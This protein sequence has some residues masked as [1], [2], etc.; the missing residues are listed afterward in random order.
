MKKIFLFAILALLP[1]TGY[2]QLSD[3]G[4]A[5]ALK[6]LDELLDDSDS[7][8]KIDLFAIRDVDLDGEMD[9]VLA[10]NDFKR[11]TV[12]SVAKDKQYLEAMPLTQAQVSVLRNQDST[13]YS[14]IVYLTSS[15]WLDDDDHLNKLEPLMI[16]DASLPKNKF[17]F[18]VGQDEITE[19]DEVKLREYTKMVF[20]PHIG[21]VYYSGKTSSPTEWYDKALVWKLKNPEFVKTEF[22]GYN[23]EEVSPIL[24]K[25]GFDK[26]ITLL[27]FSRWKKGE[28]VRS[29]KEDVKNL[30]L[31]YYRT[32]KIIGI[33]YV[34]DCA[35]N[36]RSWYRVV[37]ARKG[38]MSHYALVCLA[39]GMVASVWDEYMDLSDFSADPSDVWYGGSLEEF[40]G[41]KQTEFM[42]MWGSPKG[43]EIV[44][45]WPSLE[46]YHYSIIR[47]SGCKMQ[48]VYDDYQYFGGY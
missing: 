3:N 41:W 28:P 9:L 32:E 31:S 24:F 29:V 33:R 5:I 39:E 10:S 25:E 30:I 37:F 18:Y 46:G 42:A 23:S 20:K 7:D 26:T 43:L 11:T 2:C 45:R 16:W 12:Y 13:S 15:L 1:L 40:W 36:E 47:E 19:K 35:A 34:A 48:I 4:R 22:R 6:H 8:R 27:N 17:S 14:S 44:V 21:E 38:N